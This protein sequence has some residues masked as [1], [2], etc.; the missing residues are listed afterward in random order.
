MISLIKKTKISNQ[1]N[2]LNEV[3]KR[4]NITPWKK[5]LEKVEKSKTHIDIIEPDI[6]RDK[7]YQSSPEF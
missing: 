3:I 7:Q 2:L 4:G 1:S 5:H 6:Q